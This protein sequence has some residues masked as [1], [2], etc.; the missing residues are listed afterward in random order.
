MANNE[1]IMDKL[2]KVCVCKGI[3]RD[4]IKKSIAE[5]ASTV[6]EVNKITGCG[7]GSCKG[8]FCSDKIKKLLEV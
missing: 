3:T 4:K 8:K 2:T 5:G 1:A 6:E 7:S